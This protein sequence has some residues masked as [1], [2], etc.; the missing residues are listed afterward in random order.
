MKPS[1]VQPLRVEVND[2]RRRGRNS[3]ARMGCWDSSRSCS[4][5]KPRRNSRARMGCWNR[6]AAEAAGR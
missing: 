6:D 3:R 1:E 5:L 4:A 2:A